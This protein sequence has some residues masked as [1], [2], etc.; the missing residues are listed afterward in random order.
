VNPG[1]FADEGEG[2]R[3]AFEAG[4]QPF[5][6]LIGGQD[7]ASELTAAEA[8]QLRDG[9]D[10]L[11][12]QLEAIADRLLEEETISLELERAPWWLSLDGNGRTWSLR[13]VLTPE[14]GQRAIEAGWPEE[15]SA[16]ISSALRRLPL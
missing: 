15:A 5:S 3:L 1:S 4:R 12:Q 11:L 2:W 9:L 14:P 13:F 7:W 8:L 6:V 10:A 16:A